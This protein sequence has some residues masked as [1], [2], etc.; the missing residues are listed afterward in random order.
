MRDQ[1]LRGHQKQHIHNV[2]GMQH[3]RLS[4]E[5]TPRWALLTFGCLY[6]WKIQPINL[7]SRFPHLA[8]VQTLA[9]RMHQSLH[10]RGMTS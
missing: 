8:R 2:A 5:T 7:L 4:S 10:T 9:A 3:I 1:A 6:L